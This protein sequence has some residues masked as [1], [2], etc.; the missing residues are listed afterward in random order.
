MKCFNHPE[1]EAVATCQKCGKG[2][3]YLIIW[4]ILVLD[5]IWGGQTGIIND[6][7]NPCLYLSARKDDPDTDKNQQAEIAIYEEKNNE[8]EFVCFIC[9]FIVGNGWLQF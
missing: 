9:G 5:Y 4:N 1:R 2:L 6:H 3:C 8:E 7:R